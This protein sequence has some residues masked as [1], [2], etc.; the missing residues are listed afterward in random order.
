MR[1][2][3]RL[4]TIGLAMFVWSPNS[5]KSQI[6]HWLHRVCVY[7]GVHT[8]AASRYILQCSCRMN[9]MKRVGRALLLTCRSVNLTIRVTITVEMSHVSGG[10]RGAE[11]SEAWVVH[12]GII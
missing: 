9:S 5:K 4:H 1:L 7:W 2:L 8:Q 11:R 6:K 12:I 10:Q 3:K